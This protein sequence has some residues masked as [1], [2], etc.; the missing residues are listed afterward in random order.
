MI[1]HAVLHSWQTDKVRYINNSTEG[2]PYTSRS[3]IGDQQV[4]KWYPATWSIE[5]QNCDKSNWAKQ[6]KFISA[7]LLIY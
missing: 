3:Q 4:I 6:Q 5:D 1:P 7:S 2:L